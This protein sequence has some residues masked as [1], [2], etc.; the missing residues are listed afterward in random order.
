MNI[1]FYNE[2][3][4]HLTTF[5]YLIRRKRLKSGDIENLILLLKNM[6]EIL[7]IYLYDYL[8]E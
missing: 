1:N 6:E 3:R 8:N 7:E 5:C 4:Y 2:I